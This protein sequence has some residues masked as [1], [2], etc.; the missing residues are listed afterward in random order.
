M[1]IEINGKNHSINVKD[2]L[3]K[4]GAYLGGLGVYAVVKTTLGAL[5]ELSPNTKLKP[6]ARLGGTIIAAAAGSGT[7]FKVLNILEEMPHHFFD[8]PVEE[9]KE[10]T[11]DGGY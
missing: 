6:L 5:I 8:T 9:D 7:V 2:I 11:D 1:D 3:T 10:E 4:T